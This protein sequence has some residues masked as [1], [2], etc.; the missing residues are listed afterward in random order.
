MNWHILVLP[1]VVLIIVLAT[2]AMLLGQVSMTEIARIV[3]QLQR[4]YDGDAWHGPALR[5]ILADVTASQ[6]AFRPAPDVHSIWELTGHV[7]AWQRIVVRR[8][9]GEA[10]DLVSENENFPTIGE[11]T[12]E[13]WANQLESL[14]DSHRELIHAI[15]ALNDSRLDE[16][17]AGQKYS[18]YVMLHG[19]VQH[20]L[21]H[22]GQMALLKRLQA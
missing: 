21:Y 20:N 8:L 19:V 9:A 6:A 15:S 10:V 18:I 1:R 3:D 14:A 5:R 12:A 2:A 17:A 11:P 7:I 22:A 16:P 4:A 13:H